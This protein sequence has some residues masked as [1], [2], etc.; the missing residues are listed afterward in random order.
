MDIL[1]LELGVGANTPAIIKYPFWQMTARNENAV[2][3][4]INMGMSVAPIEI[5]DL[6]ICIGAD[7]GMVLT[8]L[9][10]TKLSH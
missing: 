8:E 6:S 3:A 5:E 7:I 10:K 1:F 9:K 2:Y 4:C